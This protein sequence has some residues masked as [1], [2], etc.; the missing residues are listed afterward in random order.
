M[1]AHQQLGAGQGRWRVCDNYA[2]AMLK[3]SHVLQNST[4]GDPSRADWGGKGGGAFCHGEAVLSITGCDLVANTAKYDGGGL[5]TMSPL[6]EAGTGNDCTNALHQF[7]TMPVLSNL[8]SGS[9]LASNR[10]GLSGGGAYVPGPRL[11][12]FSQ[13]DQLLE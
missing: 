3:D 13:H 6:T 1:H 9:L 5:F 10:A 11:P 7:F 8:V 2:L 4:P 12:G